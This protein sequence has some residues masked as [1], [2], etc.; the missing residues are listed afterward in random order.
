MV[1]GRDVVASRGR[2]LPRMY[3]NYSTAGTFIATNSQDRFDAVLGLE[4]LTAHSPRIY[5]QSATLTL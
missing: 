4:F 3:D 2:T 1:D 5:W